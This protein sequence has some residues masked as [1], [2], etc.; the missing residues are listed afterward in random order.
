MTDTDPTTRGALSKTAAVDYFGGT[1]SEKTLDGLVRRR[2][3]GFLKIGRATVFPVSALDEY[4]A[5]HT[6]QPTENPWGLTDASLAN[7]RNDRARRAS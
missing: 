4:I 7:L 1:I 5:K 3:I 6:V 2:E